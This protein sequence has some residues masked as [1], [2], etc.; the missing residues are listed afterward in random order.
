MKF[1]K[2]SLAAK[3][4][5]AKIRAMKSKS[6]KKSLGATKFIEKTESKKSKPKKT[7]QITRKSDGTFKK[8]TRIAGVKK[9]MPKKISTH[10]D[11]KSHNVR[12]SVISGLSNK[13]W[14]QVTPSGHGHYKIST[15]Y[16]GKTITCITNNMEAI[17]NY[18]SED[19]IRRISKGYNEL[20]SEVIRKN[21]Q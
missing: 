6:N 13:K 7:I 3:K 12:I 17:D 14:L 20:R 9:S 1:K 21:K 15:E 2:G 16:Y 10:K 11:T 4:Y 19:G 18:K 5:M 8:F